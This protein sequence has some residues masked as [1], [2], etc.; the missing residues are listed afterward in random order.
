MSKGKK[1]KKTVED[2]DEPRKPKKVVA[3]EGEAPASKGKRKTEK[4]AADEGEA[5]ASKGKKTKKGEAP[6]SKEKKK[7]AEAKKRKKEAE[8]E[9]VDEGEGEGDEE[10]EDE[11][12][13]E[14]RRR[15]K[16]ET[17]DEAGNEDPTQRKLEDMPAVRFYRWP[18]PRAKQ[19]AIK[20]RKL[21]QKKLTELPSFYKLATEEPKETKPKK[22]AVLQCSRFCLYMLI[23]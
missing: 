17:L 6:P 4:V 19:V 21:V 9:E 11:A 7:D 13:A 20:K 3:E 1:K 22:G 12:P 15:L 10:E 14:V 16:A 23:S 2:E 5:L 18:K 8:A